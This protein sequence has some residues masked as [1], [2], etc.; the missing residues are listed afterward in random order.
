[1]TLEE[2]WEASG[3]M[4]DRG[5]LAQVL[6]HESLLFGIEPIAVRRLL[7]TGVVIE[8]RI[9]STTG[10]HGYLPIYRPAPGVTVEHFRRVVRMLAVTPEVEQP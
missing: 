2:W 9:P 5:H 10:E 4:I 8:H 7:G 6:D 1:M 3:R